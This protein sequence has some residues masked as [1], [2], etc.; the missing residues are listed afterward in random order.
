VAQPAFNR[1]AYK[2]NISL[3]KT[4]LSKIL[5]CEMKEKEIT[6]IS[7]SYTIDF[8]VKFESALIDFY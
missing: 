4:A 8:K 2:N 6:R 3:R 1:F 7:L 5:A